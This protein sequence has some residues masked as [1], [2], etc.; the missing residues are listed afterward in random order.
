MPGG[1]QSKLGVDKTANH[2]AESPAAGNRSGWRRRRKAENRAHQENAV[3]DNRRQRRAFQRSGVL[4]QTGGGAS[5]SGFPAT[6]HDAP[7]ENRRATAG[8]MSPCHA[9]ALS[10]DPPQDKKTPARGR[11]SE[12][13]F[14]ALK[15]LRSGTPWIKCHTLNV[16]PFNAGFNAGA[17]AVQWSAS[18]RYPCLPLSQFSRASPSRSVKISSKSTRSFLSR[19]PR[20]SL[21]RW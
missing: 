7:A 15:K 17:G 19:H 2:W 16:Y 1:W 20:S 10:I 4:L 5:H 11:G 18:A 3:Q 6:P 8:R 12:T 14:A 13:R 9:R 21:P